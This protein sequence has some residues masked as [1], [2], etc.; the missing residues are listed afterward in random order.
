MIYFITGHY[1]S[2][3]SEFSLNF[4]I[5]KNIKTIVDLDIVN[6]YFRSREL[7][8]LLNKYGIEL[9][10]S[11]LKNA[12]GSDLP[13]ISHKAFLPFHDTKDAVYDIGGNEVGAR[14]LRQFK[15]SATMYMVI[16]VFRE[17]TS[18]KAGIL[19]MKHLIEGASG[20][21]VSGFINNSN[22]L[23]DTKLEDILFGQSIIKELSDEL[24]IPIVY[25]SYYDHIDV[26]Q[27]DVLGELIPLKLYLRKDWL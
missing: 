27:E 13:Y 11:P 7:E 9:I 19:K 3:K 8:S 5:L 1:G 4:A 26:K 14:I 12:L 22:L 21:Q 17:E 10:S 18:T 20:Y 24:K 23:R 2:G 25:T 6:P 15:G 16:N